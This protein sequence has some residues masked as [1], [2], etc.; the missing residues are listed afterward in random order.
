MDKGKILW[1]VRFKKSEVNKDQHNKENK[2]MVYCTD[3]SH[4]VEIIF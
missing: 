3:I 1:A 4:R 2:E